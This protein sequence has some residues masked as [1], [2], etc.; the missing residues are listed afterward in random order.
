MNAP[1]VKIIEGLLSFF[2]GISKNIRRLPEEPCLIVSNHN[3]AMDTYV[4]TSLLS[5]R[6][7]ANTRVAAARDTFA[8]GAAAWFARKTLDIVL[9]ERHPKGGRDP[10]QVLKDLLRDGRSLVIFPEGTRGEPG[11]MEHFKRGV[12]VLATAFPDFPVYPVYIHGVEKCLGRGDYLLVPFQMKLTAAETP[13]Y[14]RDSIAGGRDERAAS[15]HF[16]ERLENAVRQLGG[17]PA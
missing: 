11:I 4:L 6:H 14:G 15:L 16:T 3:S 5:A 2:F 12:G 9:V 13:L 10:L 7:A 8:G 17:R 1:A